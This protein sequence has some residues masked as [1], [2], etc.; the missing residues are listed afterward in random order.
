MSVQNSQYIGRGKSYP[1]NVTAVSYL[2]QL[3]AQAIKNTDYVLKLSLLLI[4]QARFW[5]PCHGHLAQHVIRVLLCPVLVH[6]TLQ[7]T[8]FTAKSRHL[9]RRSVTTTPVQC[10][11]IVI[12]APSSPDLFHARP[13]H[14]HTNSFCCNILLHQYHNTWR[15]SKVGVNLSADT[16]AP[17]PC[18]PQSLLFIKDPDI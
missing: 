11:S 12:S 16:R 4:R 13:N 14:L 15:Y 3:M 7:Y 6:E 17:L 2:H 8:R 10:R 5:P 1:N 18:Q 9:F